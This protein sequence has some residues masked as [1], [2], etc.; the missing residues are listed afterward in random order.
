LYLLVFTESAGGTPFH[1]IGT[2]VLE[3]SGA[4]SLRFEAVKKPNPQN[5]FENF[6][7]L[8]AL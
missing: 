1:A 7:Q 6:S 3:L 2:Y 4:A 5:R 8:E